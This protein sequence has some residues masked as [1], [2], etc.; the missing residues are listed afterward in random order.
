MLCLLIHGRFVPIADVIAPI[1]AALIINYALGHTHAK[2]EDID[3]DDLRGCER[4]L[5]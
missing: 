3:D 5:R 2:V 1:A 4:R